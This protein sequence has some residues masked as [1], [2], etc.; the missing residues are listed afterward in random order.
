VQD[1]EAVHWS[2][3]TPSVP[4]EDELAELNAP[5]VVVHA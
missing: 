3:P 2:E 5:P 4:D 1:G